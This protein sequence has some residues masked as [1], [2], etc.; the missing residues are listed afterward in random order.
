MGQG[1]RLGFE[2]S[3]LRPA[4]KSLFEAC[5][6][7]ERRQPFRIFH[8]A[9]VV[10]LILNAAW[11]WSFWNEPRFLYPEYPVT[12]RLIALWKEKFRTPFGTALATQAVFF[13]G[14]AKN[15]APELR[16]TWR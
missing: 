14:K 1:G 16:I 7:R 8:L 5:W 6:G 4:V 10:L 3:H 9:V 13:G 15:L 2:R 12:E 11:A